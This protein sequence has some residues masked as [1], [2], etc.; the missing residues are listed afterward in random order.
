MK[1][2]VAFPLTV[3]VAPEPIDAVP[4]LP[5]AHSW[6]VATEAFALTL[7]VP[8]VVIKTSDPLPRL[9]PAPTVMLPAL[10]RVSPV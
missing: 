10:M 1:K 8:F 6:I 3:S 4:P 7:K 9:P 2:F 5:L